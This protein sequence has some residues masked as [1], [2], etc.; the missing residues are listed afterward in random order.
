MTP[1]DAAPAG[2]PAGVPAP[3]CPALLL[4]VCLISSLP[5][6]LFVVFAA[7]MRYTLEPG[8]S[9]LWNAVVL[10]GLALQTLFLALALRAAHLRKPVPS[11]VLSAMVW[12]SCLIAFPVGFLIRGLMMIFKLY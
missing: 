4:R 3:G 9:A 10:S 2:A 5:V 6:M 8:R 11:L 1:A 12:A 7:T